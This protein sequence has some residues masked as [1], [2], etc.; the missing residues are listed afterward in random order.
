VDLSILR[1]LDGEMN[2]SKR[3]IGIASYSHRS[4]A[5]C[6]PFPGYSLASA[7]RWEWV[8]VAVRQRPPVKITRWE[9]TNEG[10][11]RISLDVCMRTLRL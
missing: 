9:M 11:Y 8:S 3:R 10:A 1:G 7:R 2:H 6:L 5:R 4:S